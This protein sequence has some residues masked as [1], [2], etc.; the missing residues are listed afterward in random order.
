MSVQAS[1]LKLFRRLQET[2]ALTYLFISHDLAVVRAMCQR[3][4]VMYLGKIVELGGGGRA[5][6]A[7]RAI[8]TRGR[9]SRPCPASAGGA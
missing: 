4:A 9:C 7:T 6:R 8:R 1:V 3:V 5:L 2:F